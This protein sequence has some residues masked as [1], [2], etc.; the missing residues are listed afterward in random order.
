MFELCVED[1]FSAAHQLRG[2][3]GPC[4][5]LHGHTWKVCVSLSGKTLG[6]L[7]MGVDFKEIRNKLRKHVEELDHKN[8]NDLEQFK[9]INPT[10]E[11][12]AKYLFDNL[13][14]EF[15]GEFGLSKVTVHESDRACAIY[16]E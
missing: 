2:Y 11:N 4:E 5:N 7:G 15:G 10:S 13:K 1:S 9:E 12:V 3:Q 14:P 6:V 8:L 16:Y